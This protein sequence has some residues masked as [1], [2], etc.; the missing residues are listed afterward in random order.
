MVKQESQNT[1]NTTLRG[2]G[3]EYYFQKHF[4]KFPS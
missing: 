1:Q 2:G 3:E 4:L